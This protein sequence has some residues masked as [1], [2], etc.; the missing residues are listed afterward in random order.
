MHPLHSSVVFLALAL[1]GTAMGGSSGA[2]RM[3]CE[4]VAPHV[5]LEES[6]LWKFPGFTTDLARQAVAD[7]FHLEPG[8][9]LPWESL[10][11]IHAKVEA[12]RHQ[13]RNDNRVI[14]TLHFDD[15]I[16][17][18]DTLPRAQACDLVYC[19]AYFAGWDV[20][21]VRQTAIPGTPPPTNSAPVLRP[22]HPIPY[23]P[24]LADHGH[25]ISATNPPA[26]TLQPAEPQ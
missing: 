25:L 20:D 13:P 3:P 6:R 7:G 18:S 1:A 15:K 24:D 8:T 26:L 2:D 14:V 10:R 9:E 17:D 11:G 23:S 4:T 21:R 16:L 22:Q 19:S 12:P 5:L